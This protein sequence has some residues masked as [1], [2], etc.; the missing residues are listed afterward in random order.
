MANKTS[1]TLKTLFFSETGIFC[2]LRIFLSE[3]N[4]FQLKQEFI[5]DFKFAFCRFFS[6]QMISFIFFHADYDALFQTCS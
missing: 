1:K 6:S 3:T 4:E 5:Q 2:P